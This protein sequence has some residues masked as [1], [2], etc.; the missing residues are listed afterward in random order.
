MSQV[1][2]YITN[3]LSK[4]SDEYSNVEN[5]KLFLDQIDSLDSGEIVKL[6]E[7]VGEETTVGELSSLINLSEDVIESANN[8]LLGIITG[9]RI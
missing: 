7:G 9:I 2:S 1:T 4:L 3:E 8:E 5:I 6:I